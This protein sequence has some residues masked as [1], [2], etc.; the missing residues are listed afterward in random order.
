MDR[1]GSEDDA[2]RFARAP[3]KSGGLPVFLA[4]ALTGSGAGANRDS[5]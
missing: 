2:D 1:I 3:L 5:R 4:G